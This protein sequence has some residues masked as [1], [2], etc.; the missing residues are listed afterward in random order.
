MS[1]IDL[2]AEELNN[3]L[4]EKWGISL[5]KFAQVFAV[6]PIEIFFQRSSYPFSD[7]DIR[8][9]KHTLK[10]ME[11]SLLKGARSI[12]KITDKLEEKP[13][14][15]V[16]D[17]E[18]MKE[19]RLDGFL[20]EYVHK[21][22]RLIHFEKAWL[23][24][25]PGVGMNKKSIVAV[26]WGNL[27]SEGNRRIDWKELARLYEWFWE[28]VGPYDF[29][30]EM[31]PPPGLEEYLKHQYHDHR[32]VSGAINYV[33]EKLRI[34]KNEFETFVHNIFI[35]RMAGGKEDYLKDKLGL[36]EDQ[37]ARLFK[38][39]IIDAYL[40]SVEGVTL[41]APDQSYAD[42]FFIAMQ[43]WLAKSKNENLFPSAE[44]PYKG[45]QIEDYIQFALKLYSDHNVALAELPPLIIFPNRSH[46]GTCF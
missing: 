27:V 21:Y 10:K 37:F 42:P 23:L 16:S 9:I 14:K 33:A 28:R 44:M 43:V 30:A 34:P 6:S 38:N 7:K 19:M 20:N 5:F 12:R 41:L 29:Y 17:A 36:P 26:G 31:E 25:K 39:L 40:A 45:T 4:K 46:F 35:Q 24:G 2:A 1:Y 32:W 15:K 18:L 22:E 11:D 8:E 13:A 3:R